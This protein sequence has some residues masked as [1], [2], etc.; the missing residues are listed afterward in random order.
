MSSEFRPRWLL[1]FLPV[2]LLIA[3]VLFLVSDFASERPLSPE[4]PPRATLSSSLQLKR[5]GVVSNQCIGPSDFTQQPI[6]AID[7]RL[8][9]FTTYGTF[10][11][12]VIHLYDTATNEEQWAAGDIEGTWSMAATATNLYASVNWELRAY[13]LRTGELVWRSDQL[14]G[15]SSYAMVPNPV[16]RIFLHSTDDSH[17]DSAAVIREFDLFSGKL[18]STRRLPI[19]EFSRIVPSRTLKYLWLSESG[20]ELA[21][22]SGN[23]PTWQV[24]VGE[25]IRSWPVELG[26]LLVLRVG[27]PSSLFALEASTGRTVWR[28]E[29]DLASDPVIFQGK[30]YAITVDAELVALDPSTG[31]RI[32]SIQFSP[33]VT[34][35]LSR[36]NLYSVT[37]SDEILVVYFGDSCEILIYAAAAA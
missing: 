34:N 9:Y 25:Q 28:V 18:L 15:H 7:D 35:G 13:D 27:Y 36:R 33:A 23:Q 6:L 5:I 26:N 12:G 10:Q 19:A 1:L 20:L 2:L 3:A 8:A 21:A 32:G 30:V 22:D 17:W 16:D 14:P 24:D 31:L 11:G 37:A 29:E 4:I